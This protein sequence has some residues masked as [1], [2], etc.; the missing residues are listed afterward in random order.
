MPTPLIDGKVL[1]GV[2]AKNVEPHLPSLF[3]NLETYASL[4]TS[5]FTLIVEGYSTDQTFTR[6]KEWVS[7]LPSSRRLLRQPSSSLP[8]PLSLSEARNTYLTFFE[9]Q[10]GENVYLLLLDAD[11]VNTEPIDVEGFLSCWKCPEWDMMSVNQRKVYYGIWA[12][13]NDECPYDCWDMVKKGLS[14]DRAVYV[15]QKPKSIDHPLIPCLS[16]FSG[17][18]IYRTSK[19]YGIRYYSYVSDPSSMPQQMKEVCEHVPFHLQLCKKG[20]KLFINPR[21][22]NGDGR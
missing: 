11:E 5:S 13:R 20:G 15:H 6:C 9:E 14:P 1:I 12:L 17:A 4:F 2:I 21:W 22:I 3:W 18:A 19:L 7:Y 8:R 10:F 16:A